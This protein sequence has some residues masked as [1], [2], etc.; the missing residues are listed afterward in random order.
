MVRHATTFLFAACLVIACG[1]DDPP[2]GLDAGADAADTG[3]VADTVGDA[4]ATVDAAPAEVTVM[5]WCVESTQV[6]C[7]WMYACFTPEDVERANETFGVNEENCASAFAASCQTRT[8]TSVEAGLQIFD[9]EGAAICLEA[10][11]DA[12]CGTFDQLAD[13]VAL[14]PPVCKDVTVG[15][16]EAHEECR[17]PTDCAADHATCFEGLC[18]GAREAASYEALCSDIAGDA[19]E[20]CEET[21]D[22]VAG[23]YCSAGRCTPFSECAGLRCVALPPNSIGAVGICSATCR[24]D[25]DCGDGGGCFTDEGEENF[26]LSTCESDLQCPGRLSCVPMVG[27]RSAC[28]PR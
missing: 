13:E 27:G 6:L 20:A 7:D 1:D 26:C 17:I 19:A 10:L 23:A 25:A 15:M 16:V 5:R 11:R 14:N 9:G 8:R 12:P 21:A 22:C 4:D 28:V 24:F 3:S 18:T 2:S